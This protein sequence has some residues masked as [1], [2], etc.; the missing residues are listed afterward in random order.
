MTL[1][2]GPTLRPHLV[3]GDEGDVDEGREEH[4][5]K[6]DDHVEC[7]GLSVGPSLLGLGTVVSEGDV[8]L[9]VKRDDQDDGRHEGQEWA[10]EVAQASEKL[11]ISDEGQST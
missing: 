8:V 11:N 10:V 1:R 5:D 9:E 4:I 6:G 2:E 7:P 3:E